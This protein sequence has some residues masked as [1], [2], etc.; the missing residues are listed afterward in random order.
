[1]NERRKDIPDLSFYTLRR[2]AKRDF[3]IEKVEPRVRKLVTSINKLPDIVSY[4]SCEGHKHTDNESQ[5]DEGCFTVGF[6]VKPTTQGL[7]S[8]GIIHLATVNVNENDI[9]VS[10]DNGTYNPAL[11]CFSV[12][13]KNGVSP[14]K[15]A[16]EI[17]SMLKGETKNEA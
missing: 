8:L 3:D 4:T 12:D 16:D 13:G 11:V 1:M 10:V 15:V 2:Y 7:K 9:S 5:V 6:F 14:D 17:T